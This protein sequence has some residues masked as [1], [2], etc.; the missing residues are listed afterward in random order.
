MGKQ[1]KGKQVSEPLARKAGWE[2]KIRH[3]SR[4]EKLVA[5]PKVKEVSCLMTLRAWTD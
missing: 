1:D 2:R 4:V 3:R 5:R